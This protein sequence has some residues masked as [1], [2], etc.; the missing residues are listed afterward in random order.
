MSVAVPIPPEALPV[1]TERMPVRGI[2]QEARAYCPSCGE[3]TTAGHVAEF[4]G[5]HRSLCKTNP[6][7]WSEREFS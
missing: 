1:A 6:R 7:G 2:W 4:G 3:E 5:C